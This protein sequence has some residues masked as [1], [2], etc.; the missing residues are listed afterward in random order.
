MSFLFGL[1]I[2]R[3]Y[4]KFPGCSGG[5]STFLLGM[6]DGLIFRGY[7]TFWEGWFPTESVHFTGPAFDRFSIPKQMSR[8]RYLHANLLLKQKRT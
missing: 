6:R 7:V 5:E 1:P 4:V 3:G 8:A 2:F